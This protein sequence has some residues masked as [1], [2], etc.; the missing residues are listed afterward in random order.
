MSNNLN[1][2]TA[3]NLYSSDVQNLHRDPVVLYG[4][5]SSMLYFDAGA[6]SPDRAV[7][8]K[9]AREVRGG[10]RSPCLSAPDRFAGRIYRGTVN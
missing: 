5:P 1:R 2:S 9:Q 4:G 8:V 10:L 6:P 3:Q 7:Y